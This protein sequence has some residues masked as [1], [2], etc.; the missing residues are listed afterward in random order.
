MSSCWATR[1]AS[2]TSATQQQ[3]VSLSPPHS[4]IVTPSTS[5]PWSSSTA[6]A[7]D[8]S[9][10]PL[11]AS[12]TFTSPPTSPARRRGGG[13]RSARRRRGRGR[14]R[15][16]WWLWPSEKR[17]AP[18]AC[19]FATPIAAS[20]CDGSIAPLA[21]AEAA[22]A[23]TPCLVEQEEQRLALD[24]LEAHVGRTG[25]LV[26]AGRPSRSLPG[27]R[28]AARRRTGRASRSMRAL[29][30]CPLG[31]RSRRS[32]SAKATMPATL[33]VPLRRSRS[34][35]PPCTIGSKAHPSRTN[36]TPTPFGPPNLWAP[37][38][39]A[40]RRA[41]R[42]GHEVE[43]ARCLDRR[44][45]GTPPA[46][47][48]PAPARRSRR[49]GCTVPTSLLTA[50]I[51]TTEIGV[52]RSSRSAASSSASSTRPE[53][54]TPTTTPPRCSTGCSTA[55]CSTAEHTATRRV[56]GPLRCTA[57]L[58]ASVPHPVKT[59]SPGCTPRHSATTSRASSNALRASRAARCE[60]LGLAKR[61][62][63][64]GSIASTA[65]RP[66][67]RRR[68]VVEVGER[69]RDRHRSRGYDVVHSRR[70][71]LR[72]PSPT[73][74]PSPTSTTTG[75]STSAT[76]PRRSISLRRLAGDGPGA[77]ARRRHRPD[78]RSRSAADGD[79]GRRHR[80]QRGDAGPPA[81]AS[82]AEPRCGPSWRHDARRAARRAV[83][84]RVRRLQ[85][86]LQPAHRGGA[87]PPASAPWRRDWPLA[88]RSCSRP[89]C[90]RS[91]APR[92]LGDRA[93][94]H[95]CRPR[96]ARVSRHD[97]TDQRAEGQFVELTEAS[98]VRL[99]PWAIRYSTP[100]Q[101]DA[102]AAGAGLRLERRVA[103]W[104]GE[105]FTENSDRHV[106]VFVRS[107]FG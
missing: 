34:W 27:R 73:A 55:W 30:A 9:T 98:G 99:R 33:C 68:R 25:D 100:A 14:H 60:P 103:S 19:S 85:H 43:P 13:P 32:A 74:R 84:A 22:L 66:H 8:E 89:S 53:R 46:A 78:R 62:E 101:L 12:R 56:G 36:S 6:A 2:S 41:A 1:R 107:A 40:C 97:G 70:E 21:H 105:S 29:V 57:A 3:P 28:R 38:A 20:T 94:E 61:S 93:A 42:K 37:T 18:I 92:W 50:M 95:G 47:R 58:S 5:W 4:R 69:R 64:K 17:I 35:P 77:R 82:R 11:I 106:S 102:M 26:G 86:V 63:R 16:R 81:R 76:S 72:R 39:R 15:R 49:V 54:S 10:P 52:D 80:R 7:T 83:R 65:S 48:V 91:R 23:H 75:T 31:R 67:R 44:R 90:R 71:G 59:T 96:R 45:C 24:A 51:D 104:S 79:R 87:R 88:E